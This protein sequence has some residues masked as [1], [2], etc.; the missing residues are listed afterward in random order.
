MEWDSGDERHC[1]INSVFFSSLVELGMFKNTKKRTS[2]GSFLMEWDSGD[3][4]HCVINSVFFS[5]LFELGMFKN[6]KKRTSNGS[7]FNGA[8]DEA[9]TR[10]ILLGK[11]AFYH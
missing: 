4:R 8:G 6:A 10:D 1:V 3:E 5:S 9:R 11:E 7:F 2:N